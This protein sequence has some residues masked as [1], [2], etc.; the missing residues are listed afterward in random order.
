MQLNAFPV[1]QKEAR[2]TGAEF[3]SEKNKNS[4]FPTRL[5]ELRKEKGVSQQECADT[6]GVSKSTLGLWEN[7]DT[8]PD[9]RSL[10]QMAEYYGV[11][12]DYMLGVSEIKSPDVNIQKICELTGLTEQ[13]AK[14]L[15]EN[16][17][18]AEDSK[19]G[20]LEDQ[21]QDYRRLLDAVNTLIYYQPFLLA[22]IAEYLYFRFDH[23]E[24]DN[25][26]HISTGKTINALGK[27]GDGSSYAVQVTGEKLA[28]MKLLDIEK[29]LKDLRKDIA[30]NSEDIDTW[31]MIW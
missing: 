2:Q 25:W 19:L 6:L 13:A 30:E 8:L 9:A 17:V 15:I 7:G 28:D 29:A 11:S 31:H 14:L 23:F 26:S 1:T 3:S 22:D 4:L 20:L 5:R 10:A 24:T 21:K 12:A 18:Q 16:N 27:Y